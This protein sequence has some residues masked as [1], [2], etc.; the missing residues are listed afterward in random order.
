MSDAITP[1]SANVIVFRFSGGNRDGQ[2]VRSDQPRDGFDEAG[3]FWA[4][5][6]KGTAG[7][8]FDVP[9]AGCPGAYQRYKVVSKY[10]IG[11]EVRVH[12]EHV[13]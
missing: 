6:R 8:R 4:M 5:T 9:V 11:G 10:E 1:P 13:G 3:T 7:R 12:C 2:E